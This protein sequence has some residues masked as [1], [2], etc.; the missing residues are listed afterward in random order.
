MQ[1]TLFE[2]NQ[3]NLFW[4]CWKTENS[5]KMLKENVIYID[6]IFCCSNILIFLT[7]VLEIVP[8]SENSNITMVF[9][10]KK[11][12]NTNNYLSIYFTSFIKTLEHDIIKQSNA[13]I[14]I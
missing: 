12:F 9:Y 11:L 10:N 8:I 5:L 1:D 2:S 4:K 3:S 13:L 14:I 6:T 7:N